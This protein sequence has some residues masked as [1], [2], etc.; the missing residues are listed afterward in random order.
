MFASLRSQIPAPVMWVVETL[1]RKGYHAHVVGGCVRDLLMGRAPKD[2][3]VTTSA[4]PGETVALF[5]KV[6]PTGMKHG[7]VT[8]LVD[9]EPI[10]V[11]TYR[12]DGDY[13]DG[14]RPD[15]VR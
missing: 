4:L 1:Q 7:T 15:S 14:R 13:S 11:T 9:A 6:I 8:V 2:W 3:D 10:E 12:S 5:P